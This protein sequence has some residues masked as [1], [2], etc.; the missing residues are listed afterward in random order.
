MAKKMAH[1]DVFAHNV[2]VDADGRSTLCDFGAAFFYDRA[3]PHCPRF[4]AA[5]VRAQW[6]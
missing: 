1:G 4:E 6:T 5:E 3:D 2:L